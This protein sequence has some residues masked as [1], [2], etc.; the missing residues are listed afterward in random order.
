MGREEGVDGREMERKRLAVGGCKGEKGRTEGGE[1]RNERRRE[2]KK[3][4]K[5]GK[6]RSRKK[7]NIDQF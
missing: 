2:R 6:E 5:Q 7:K 4:I 1:E 3:G